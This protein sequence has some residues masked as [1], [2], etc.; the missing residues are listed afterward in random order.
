MS[1]NEINKVTIEDVQAWLAEVPV[2]ERQDKLAQFLV[3]ILRGIY[4]IE[5]ARKELLSTRRGSLV[6]TTGSVEG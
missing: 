1:D 5:E 3:S 4:P 6:N 2:S